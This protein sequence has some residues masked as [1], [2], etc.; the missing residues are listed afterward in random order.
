MHT[1]GTR[2]AS[3][4]SHGRWPVRAPRSPPVARARGIGPA[5]SA[6][7]PAP[8]A[9]TEGRMVHGR[10]KSVHGQHVPDPDIAHRAHPKP[11]RQP[12]RPLPHRQRPHRPTSVAP[13]WDPHAHPHGRVGQPPQPARTRRP[14]RHAPPAGA[15]RPRA[16]HARPH[17]A[18]CAAPAAAGAPPPRDAQR[19]HRARGEPPLRGEPRARQAPLVARRWPRRPEPPR[20]VRVRALNRAPRLP[21]FPPPPRP[22]LRIRAPAL[23]ARV[24]TTTLIRAAAAC[25]AWPGPSR[26]RSGGLRASRIASYPAG[27]RQRPVLRRPPHPPR[28]PP[29]RRPRPPPGPTGIGR[30]PPPRDSSQPAA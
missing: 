5:C 18:P 22:P 13:A 11:L 25:R 20:R 21:P 2:A 6:R 7:L 29:G 15:R 28:R 23:D 4:A 27:R 17:R 1:E 9:H 19:Q 14:A 24:P 26:T 30:G 3:P 10:A 8:I 16:L 12:F